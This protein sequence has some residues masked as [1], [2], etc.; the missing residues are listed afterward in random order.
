M[1]REK[2]KLIV[3]GGPMDGLEFEVDRPELTIG[4]R[5]DQ[6]FCLPLDP[7][8]SRQHARLT[9]EGDEYWLE[10][11]G[12]SNG[13]FIADAEDKIEGR[14]VLFLGTT[15]R[16]GPLTT[17]KLKKVI[18]DTELVEKRVIRRAKQL[19]RRLLE[20][21]PAARD[22]LSPEKRRAF[23]QQMAEVVKQLDAVSTM[24]ELVGVLQRMAEVIISEVGREVL[25]G[26]AAGGVESPAKRCPA[27]DAEV[28]EGEDL[29][30]IVDFIKTN[31]TELIEQIEKEEP[32]GEGGT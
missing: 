20:G 15:F 18:E 22:S 26:P 23:R 3:L 25:L 16:L 2:V 30:S 10:D 5:D 31:L 9:V 29:T 24:E 32:P 13:V 19:L 12:S 14:V 27:P 4:R 1:K 28:S 21:L 8:V 11:V 7:A 17:L 6:D